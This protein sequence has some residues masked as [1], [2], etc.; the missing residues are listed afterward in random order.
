[1]A[2]EKGLSP[3]FRNDAINRITPQHIWQMPGKVLPKLK[4]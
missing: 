4:G 1:M 2:R 3:W